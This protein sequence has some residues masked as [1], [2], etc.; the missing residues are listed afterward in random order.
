MSGGKETT[1]RIVMVDTLGHARI[2]VW[3]AAFINVPAPEKRNML[4]AAI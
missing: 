4:N 1:I 2:I 3:T